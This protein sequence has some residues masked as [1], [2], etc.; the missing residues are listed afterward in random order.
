MVELELMIRHRARRILVVCPASLQVQWRDQMRDKFGLDFRIVDSELMRICGES[1]A[2]M[3]T[4]GRI[5]P[6]SSR[7]S[8]SS[9][10]SVP[11]GCSGKP[12]RRRRVGLSPPLRHLVVDEAHNVPR[13]VEANTP[14]IPCAPRPCGSWPRTSST[15]CFSPPR[16]TTATRR[17]SRHSWSCWTISVSLVARCPT[18]N[19]LGR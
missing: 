17:V 1:G 18:E 5:S 12:C 15:S 14:P 7:P 16:P 2:S 19:S 10:G 4:P 13:L 8:T 9:S 3:S 6:G 11:C